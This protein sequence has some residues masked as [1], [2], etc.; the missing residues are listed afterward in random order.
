MCLFFSRMCNIFP[1]LYA[2]ESNRNDIITIPLIL[3]S[4]IVALHS[5]SPQRFKLKIKLEKLCT[6]DL[7]HNKRLDTYHIASQIF[8]F[9]MNSV[10]ICL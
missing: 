4:S 2:L 6:H 5:L 3:C 7:D 8:L 1:F 9:V 10:T